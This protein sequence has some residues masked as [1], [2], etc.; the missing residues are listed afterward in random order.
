[1]QYTYHVNVQY[2][3]IYTRTH[4]IHNSLAVLHTSYIS[5]SRSVLC[6]C[7][8]DTQGCQDGSLHKSKYIKVLGSYAYISL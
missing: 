8:D 1:M 3:Y 7:M 5:C 4:T 2:T 6:I